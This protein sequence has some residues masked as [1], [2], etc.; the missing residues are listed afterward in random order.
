MMQAILIKDEYS[1]LS[2]DYPYEVE[3]VFHYTYIKLKGNPRRYTSTS[4][5][6]WHN[7]KKISHREAYRQYKLKIVKEKLGIK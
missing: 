3:R 1:D 4:F 7:G 5:E 2:M 6:I